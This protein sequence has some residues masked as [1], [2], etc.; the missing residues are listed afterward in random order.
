MAII[1]SLS[2]ILKV[3]ISKNFTWMQFLSMQ[4]CLP[5]YWSR[6]IKKILEIFYHLINCKNNPICFLSLN[7]I[8]LAFIYNDFV[9]FIF[10]C[11]LYNYSNRKTL[12]QSLF[13]YC[14]MLVRILH[15]SFL[16]H[17]FDFGRLRYLNKQI[18]VIICKTWIMFCIY[19]NIGFNIITNLTC[20]ITSKTLSYSLK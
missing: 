19:S 11:S 3:F 4:I 15:F 17:S 7:F 9:D 20:N 8:F 16:Y 18:V 10:N 6:F 14:S 13:N 12:V 2:L 1:I 5:F